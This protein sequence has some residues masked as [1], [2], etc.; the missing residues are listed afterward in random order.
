[1][2]N[3][4]LGHNGAD[5]V[6]AAIGKTLA[7][8]K[9]DKEHNRLELRFDDGTGVSL[10]DDGHRCCESRYMTCDDDLS[11]YAGAALNDVT[12]RDAPGAGDEDKVHEVQFLAVLTSKGEFTLANHNEHNGYYSG[13]SIA[14]ELLEEVP[15]P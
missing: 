15:T 7:S 4:L 11:D 10:R 5:H 9:L 2:I 1:M 12:V 14:A 13:F 6:T 3:H 8:V